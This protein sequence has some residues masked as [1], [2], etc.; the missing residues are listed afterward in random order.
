M[1]PLRLVGSFVAGAT[2]SA[3]LVLT[4]TQAWQVGAAPGDTDATYQPL[5]P[6]RLLDTRSD[7]SNV[8]D[9]NTP[10][11]P[12]EVFTAQV[13]GTNG[14]CLAVPADATGVAMNVTVLNATAPSF[15]TVFPADLVDVPVVSNLNFSQASPPTP[16][17]VDS[18][19]APDGKIK[20]FNAFGNVDVI[21]DVV[22]VYTNSSLVDIQKRLLA[23]EAEDGLIYAKI[24]DQRPTTQSKVGVDTEITT[25]WTKVVELSTPVSR[26]GRV[27]AFASGTAFEDTAG[28]DVQCVITDTPD[29]VVP[30]RGMLW[31]ASGATA[32]NK[33]GQGDAGVVSGTRSFNVVGETFARFALMCR[34][35]VSGTSTIWDPQI[36]VLFIRN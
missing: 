20:I 27:L 6:C 17:K 1:P 13:T 30:D 25:A 5:N 19:L 33:T 21:V 12:G 28:H 11:G 9:R 24:R 15:L 18:K 4:G 22:G 14:N 7:A 36:T 26:T 31:E 16:N 32:D 34:N 3:A 10:V 2:L 35:T 29:S 23:L 8:G